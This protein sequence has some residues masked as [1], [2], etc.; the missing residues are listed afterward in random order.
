MI[1]RYADGRPDALLQKLSVQSELCP[2]QV[3]ADPGFV[4]PDHHP[5]LVPRSRPHAL[6]HDGLH[7]R[8]KGEDEQL[9]SFSLYRAGLPG[10]S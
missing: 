3:L 4:M 6:L 7:V 1:E 8:V 2:I 9:F 10:R 5:A